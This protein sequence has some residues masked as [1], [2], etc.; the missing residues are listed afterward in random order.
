MTSIVEWLA[1]GDLRSDGAANTVVE[2]VFND[3]ALI[4]EIMAGLDDEREVVRGRCA[5]VLE[6]VARQH[7]ECFR[8][9]LDKLLG[10][11]KTDEVPMVRWHL[12]MLLGHVVILREDHDLIAEALLYLVADDSVFTLS[13]AIV[14]MCI[15]ARVNPAFVQPAQ[16]TIRSLGSH[17]SKA[18]RA[19]VRYS[20]PLLADP[21]TPFP[22]GWI[23]SEH[24]ERL[25]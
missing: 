1:G 14:S 23:K 2:A 11:L 19:K 18:I 4:P 15:L 5:D 7:P 6:K 21:S 17:P 24:V 13:W 25:M 9:H 16:E 20:L 12:A 22:S 8:S 3:L 10:V